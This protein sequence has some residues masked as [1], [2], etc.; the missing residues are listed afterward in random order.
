MNMNMEILDNY[1]PP[2]LFAKLREHC[3]GLS[4]EGVTNPVDGVF[5]PGIS[6]EIPDYVKP[7]FGHPKFMFMR[8]SL[9]GV[10]VPHQAHTD[11]VMGQ[12]SLMFYLNR[13]EH[14]RGGTSLVRHLET[15][16]IT[17]PQTVEEEQIWKR[18]TNIPRAWE[19]YE[20]SKMQPNRAV[21][22]PANL[23]HRAEPLGGFGST[24]QDGRLVL[25]A[26]Y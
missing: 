21:V 17:D 2:E 22:F 13:Q 19:I 11:T 16:M 1:L 6:L 12:L 20:I 25:T 24:P 26:F 8:L 14:A 15:G 9:A 18:D 5:Y 4:Y 3:D 23:M 7:Y 10:P